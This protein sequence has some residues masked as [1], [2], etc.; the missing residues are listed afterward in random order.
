MPGNLTVS[1]AEAG[2]GRPLSWAESLWVERTA[3]WSPYEMHISLIGVL[4]AAYICVNTPF[5]LVQCL[6]ISWLEQYR[7]QKAGPK[8]QDGRTAVLRCI[9]TI[10][11][12]LFA[13]FGPLAVTAFPI[14]Q[15]SKQRQSFSSIN[16]LA[17]LNKA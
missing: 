12:D 2:L 13:L 11:G 7:I 3:G 10:L 8:A 17:P 5:L 6:N 14:F 4:L 1:A 15:V 16:C 9:T